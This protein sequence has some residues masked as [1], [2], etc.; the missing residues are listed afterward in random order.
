MF[1]FNFNFIYIKKY[2]QA[3]T[4]NSSKRP[5]SHTRKFYKYILPVEK[6][7][8]AETPL[9]WPYISQR[10]L[11]V[12]EMASY[13]MLSSSALIQNWFTLFYVIIKNSYLILSQI[14]YMSKSDLQIL[15]HHIT[16]K[17]G[18]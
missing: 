16:K 4:I 15:F 2:G 17:N 14:H 6:D 10:P 12:L 1:A 9:K 18:K 11:L 13:G 5:G 3:F 8:V 7:E